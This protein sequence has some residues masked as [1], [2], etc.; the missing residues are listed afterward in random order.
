MLRRSTRQSLNTAGNSS[1]SSASKK[2]PRK[3]A[4]VASTKAKG[5]TPTKR[6]HFKSTRGNDNEDD[7]D[8]STSS[9]ESS[10]PGTD[11][12]DDFAGASQHESS[13]PASHEEDDYSDE[14]PKRKRKGTTPKSSTQ[15]VL[16]E[17]KRGSEL[18]R[19]G[20][21]TGLPLGTQVIIKKPKPRAA[22]STPY[23][24]GTIHPNTLLFL[25]DLKANND[26]EW[27]KS[28]SRSSGR[29]IHE[30][31]LSPT[32]SECNSCKNQWFVQ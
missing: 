5:K 26:R 15:G 24:A 28:K 21:T 9:S 7:E 16:P 19:E 27:F 11:N 29:F 13:S 25:A 22:G 4:R 3:K 17:T 18:W 2:M 32:L 1:A 20:V 30:L 10:E 23:S 8:N 12:E 14:Q 6:P 31:V